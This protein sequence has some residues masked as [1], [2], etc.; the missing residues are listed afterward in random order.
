MATSIGQCAPV[1]LPGE[2]HL[3]NREAWQ[4]IVYRV[5]DL[6]TTEVTL[7]E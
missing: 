2:P 3:P 1:F 5:A 4:A 7:R 6:D